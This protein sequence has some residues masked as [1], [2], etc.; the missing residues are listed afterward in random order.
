MA[1]NSY[2]KEMKC[3]EIIHWLNLNTYSGSA[4]QFLIRNGETVFPVGHG[5]PHEIKDLVQGGLAQSAGLPEF[6]DFLREHVYA[7]PG[8]SVY[9]NDSLSLSYPAFVRES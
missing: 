4:H 8:F 3:F 9:I 1:D 5:T 7:P 2:F 6:P